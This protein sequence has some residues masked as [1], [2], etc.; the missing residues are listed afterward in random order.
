[1]RVPVFQSIRKLMRPEYTQA[2][3]EISIRSIMLV[4]TPF[5]VI[6][7]PQTT[8]EWVEHLTGAN[9]WAEMKRYT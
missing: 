1:M 7:N 8:A 6:G 5:A 2:S 3:M 9:I 4:Y